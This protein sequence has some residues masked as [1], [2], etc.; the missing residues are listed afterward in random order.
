MTVT[1]KDILYKAAEDVQ[2]GMWCMGQ[3]FEDQGEVSV[4]RVYDKLTDR[5]SVEQMQSSPRC[6]EGSLVLSTR[7]LGGTAEDYGKAVGAV[8][9]R[10]DRALFIFNDHSLPNDP[11]SAGQ[12]LAELFRSTA[13]AL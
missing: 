10:I 7:L 3:W 5:L 13:D 8:E 9:A 12:Q 1:T 6:A 11:F 2:Q 4:T